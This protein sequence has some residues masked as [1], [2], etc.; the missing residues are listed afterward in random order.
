MEKERRD[1]RR[2]TVLNRAH[3]SGEGGEGGDIWAS[4]GTGRGGDF[5]SR[6]FSDG[7]KEGEGE[8]RKTGKPKSEGEKLGPVLVQNAGC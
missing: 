2:K 5:S 4:F 3:G 6:D 7:G 1:E 8:K